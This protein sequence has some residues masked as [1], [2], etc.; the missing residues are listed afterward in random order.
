MTIKD[1]RPPEDVPRLSPTSW[2]AAA[3]L[4]RGA[5]LA[6][7]AQGRH[8]HRC[9][10]HRR[11]D[12]LRGPPRRTRRLPRRQRAQAAQRRL[13]RCGEDGGRGPAGRRRRTRLQQPDDRRH[14]LLR[15]PPGPLPRRWR[16]RGDD[17]IAR[18]A[19]QATQVTRQLLA[20]SRR[21]VLQPK[22]LDLNEIV[23]HMDGLLRRLIGEHIDLHTSRTR[24]SPPSGRTRGRSSSVIMNLVV[25][26]P[27]RDA[28]R[29]AADDRNPRTS[30]WIPGTS[31][32]PRPDAPR[33]PRPPCRLR[34]RHRDGR[35]D[36]VPPLRALLHHQGDRHRDGAGP[37]DG[38]RHREA[39]RR[40]HLGLQRGRPRHDIQDLLARG[41]G[42]PRRGRAGARTGTRGRHRDDHGRSR[43]TTASA[44]SCG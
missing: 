22:V 28:Q 6:A 4:A 25:Q 30:S 10:G 31:R 23:L 29:R 5:D 42:A 12:R 38:V 1:I 27:R 43:T 44:N 7:P 20:F 15:D 14:G 40:R 17:E 13:C 34:H 26:R 24:T 9:R 33:P 11:P 35:R 2:G 32:P 21:Q 41:R 37:R 39:D 3:R 18:A 36:P 16:H 8:D 19:G